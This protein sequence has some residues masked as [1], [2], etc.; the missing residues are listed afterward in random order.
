MSS[1]SNYR[2]KVHTLNLTIDL[3][4]WDPCEFW[5]DER[6]RGFH[7]T[8]IV[9]GRS[10]LYRFGEVYPSNTKAPATY[11]FTWG[12]GDGRL[13]SEFSDHPSYFEMTD[14]QWRKL[15]ELRDGI[16]V[17]TDIQTDT[18]VSMRL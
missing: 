18:A 17:L 4:K 11:S 12:G 8:T 13:L 6:G 5:I 10:Q 14:A 16:T 9:G 1:T 7:R 2:S 3:S 15:P